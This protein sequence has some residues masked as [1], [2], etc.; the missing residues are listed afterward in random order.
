MHKF[1]VGIYQI[2]YASEKRMLQITSRIFIDDLND[3]LERKHKKKFHIGETGETAE[4]IAL[5]SKYLTEKFRIEINGK[6][7]P[8]TFLSN[9]FES[10]VIICYLNIREVPTVRSLQIRN[11]VLFDHVT[12]QQN[13]IQTT[14]NGKKNSLLLTIDEPQ[15]SLKF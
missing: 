13:I 12:E 2:N 11:E 8:L 15:G 3:A 6:P 7:R 14:I 10:N 4:E 1:Y 5:M 9:E